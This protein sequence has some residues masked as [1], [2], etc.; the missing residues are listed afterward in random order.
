LAQ[1]MN[2]VGAMALNFTCQ[3]GDVISAAFVPTIPP[4]R[5]QEIIQE[6]GR[7]TAAKLREAV[8]RMANFDPE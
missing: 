2:L 4:D 1:H 7:Q 8:E 3:G 6:R 5:L